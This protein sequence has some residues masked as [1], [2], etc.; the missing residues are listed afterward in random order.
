MTEFSGEPS[1][2]SAFNNKWDVHSM[3]AEELFEEDWKKA[4]QPNCD[5]YINRSK[6]KC[7][8]HKEMRDFC[9]TLGFGLVYGLTDRGLAERAKIA[10]AKASEQIRKFF[11]KRAF[12]KQ[13][14]DKAAKIAT[15]KFEA[16]TLAQRRRLFPRPEWNDAAK[17]A[18]ERWN[19]LPSTKEIAQQLKIMYSKIE[20][21]GKNTPIQGSGVDMMKLAMGCGFDQNGKPYLWHRLEPEFG[22]KLVNMVH[23]ELDVETRDEVAE[24]ALAVVTDCMTRAGQE[25][26]KRIPT[27]ADGHIDTKW[28]KG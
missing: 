4:A 12:L 9:K 11:S 27:P 28:S 13:W 25:L 14:L 16:R 17:F 18:Q 10:L 5:Y 23:D 21:K 19:R 26:I 22:A 8:L 20:R 6:C 3:N 15:T 1:W 7:K 2:V 24:P